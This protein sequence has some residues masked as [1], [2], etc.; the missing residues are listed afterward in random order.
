MITDEADFASAEAIYTLNGVA[1]GHKASA[2][3]QRRVQNQVLS[4]RRGSL[5]DEP[6]RNRIPVILTLAG[7]DT[8]YDSEYQIENTNHRQKDRTNAYCN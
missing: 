8:G 2:P 7:F 6:D 4:Q 1:A 5:L 3:G